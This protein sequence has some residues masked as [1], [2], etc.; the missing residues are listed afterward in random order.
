MRACARGLGSGL[1]VG[2]SLELLH[3]HSVGVVGRN[4]HI[5]RSEGVVNRG[6]A[7]PALAA[8]FLQPRLR[9]LSDP[10]LLPNMTT[11][12]DRLFRARDRGEALVIFGDYDVDGVSSTALLTEVLRCLEWKV[13]EISKATKRKIINFE[14]LKKNK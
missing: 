14:K 13:S 1:G 8:N 12:V 3:G 5:A 9:Q 10:F 6:L 7:E 4:S 11:A 2:G